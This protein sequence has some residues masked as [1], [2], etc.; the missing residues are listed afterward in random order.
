MSTLIEDIKT[1][2]DANP[3]IDWKNV[4]LILNSII[5]GLTAILAILPEGIIK[6]LLKVAID[7]ITLIIAQLPDDIAK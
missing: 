1:Q 7:I 3:A 2:V 6:T 5:G 4:K